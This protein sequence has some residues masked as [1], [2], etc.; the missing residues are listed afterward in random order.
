LQFPEDLNQLR[1]NTSMDDPALIS[2][3]EYRRYVANVLRE[4]AGA[5][6]HLYFSLIH[7]SLKDAY[8]RDVIM[9]EAA[10]ISITKM[11]DSIRRNLQV[12]DLAAKMQTGFVKAKLLETNDRANSGKPAPGFTA[13]ALNGKEFT[14]QDLAGKY[15]VI[16]FKDETCELCKKETPYFESHADRY[17]SPEVAFISLSLDPDK[18]TWQKQAGLKK[19]TK[20]FQLFLKDDLAKLSLA[21]GLKETPRFL[22]IDQKG[23][24]LHMQMPMPSDPEFETILQKELST[25]NRYD[26]D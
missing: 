4:K 25:Q 13:A 14:T 21:Y 16:E 1:A 8:T 11:K 24:I 17:T 2:F 26:D 7:D 20:A 10:S 9:Y 22:L 15:L 23:N 19:G 12:A 5:N 18:K 6:D 3:P